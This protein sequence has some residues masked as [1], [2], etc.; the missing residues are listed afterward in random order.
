VP[1]GSVF[2]SE[3]GHHNRTEQQ[4]VESQTLDSGGQVLLKSYGYFKLFALGLKMAKSC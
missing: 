4:S 1:Y 2:V 3:D